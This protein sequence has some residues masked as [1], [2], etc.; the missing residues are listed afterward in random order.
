M[1]YHYRIMFFY[2]SRSFKN[3]AWSIY[4]PE[5]TAAAADPTPCIEK[6]A[7]GNLMKYH[8]LQILMDIVNFAY[9]VVLLFLWFNSSVCF[10][11]GVHCQALQITCKMFWLVSLTYISLLNLLIR[12]FLSEF[13]IFCRN[14]AVPKRGSLHCKILLLITLVRLSLVYLFSQ[15]TSSQE[16]EPVLLNI[17]CKPSLPGHTLHC[18]AKVDSFC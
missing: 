1:F 4:P 8:D 10:W 18:I 17:V 12:F 7:V 13:H 11:K 9:N 6:P 3:F 16:G 14:L 2:S 5:F 15:F